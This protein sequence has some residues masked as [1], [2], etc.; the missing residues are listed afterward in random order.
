MKTRSLTFVPRAGPLLLALCA[1]GLAMPVLA[2]TSEPTAVRAEVAKSLKVDIAGGRWA[3][4]GRG[5]TLMEAAREIAAK[6]PIDIRIQDPALE[7]TKLGIEFKAPN[8]KEAMAQ[9][10]H[11]YNYSQFDDPKTGRQVY[12]VS[13]LA[14]EVKPVPA[15]RQ[16]IAAAAPPAAQ[17]S[18]ATSSGSRG[19][20][21]IDEFRPVQPATVKS[22]EQTQAEIEADYKREREEKLARAIDA[23]KSKDASA[24][25][26]QQALAELAS[27]GDPRAPAALKDAWAQVQG[28]PAA[29]PQVAQSVWRNAA[30][31]QFA[32]NEANAL[33]LSLA[34]S[35]NP[36]V[37]E[38]ALAGKADM[39]RFRA[40]QNK[41]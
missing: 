25:V 40:V 12:L 10:L 21:S 26:Q 35:Q 38:V 13:S 18:G 36:A 6:A 2:A 33:L 17:V 23:L 15:E 30:Q 8:A 5:V 9:V 24:T 27:S 7:T 16:A 4:T 22:R 14:T 3:F 39:E 41:P 29:G 1:C 34:S 32:N 20:R 31:Q 28:I 19:V 37:R 11:G